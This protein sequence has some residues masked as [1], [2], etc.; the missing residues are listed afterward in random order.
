MPILLRQK[1]VSMALFPLACF[2]HLQQ[3]TYL[4]LPYF[5][6]RDFFYFAHNFLTFDVFTKQLQGE[7]CTQ[8][9]SVCGPFQFVTTTIDQ[10]TTYTG[11]VNY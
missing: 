3:G 1:R 11:S 7:T 8:P 6:N 9:S 10:S 4:S 2:T 5:I